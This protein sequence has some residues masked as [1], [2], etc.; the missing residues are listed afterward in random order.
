MRRVLWI[1]AILLMTEAFAAAMAEDLFTPKTIIPAGVPVADGRVLL[2]DLV[3][4]PG[5]DQVTARYADGTSERLT[6][7][8]CGLPGTKKSMPLLFKQNQTPGC[9]SDLVPLR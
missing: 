3:I 1:T 6:V 4:N 5:V 9:P 8:R 7:L 2:T